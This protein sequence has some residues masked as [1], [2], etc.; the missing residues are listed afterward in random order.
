MLLFFIYLFVNYFFLSK[1]AA[2]KEK[3]NLRLQEEKNQHERDLQEIRSNSFRD[4]TIWQQKI[5]QLL[6]KAKVYYFIMS[7][8]HSLF[9]NKQ[10]EELQKEAEFESSV[11]KNRESLQLNHAIEIE[12]IY[13]SF[14]AEKKRL[15]VVIFTICVFF[16]SLKVRRN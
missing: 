16:Y 10:S 8:S 14:R 11:V 9:F 4:Q 12:K 13:D 3:S 7:Y 15:Q 1:L 6:Q 5:A 2:E